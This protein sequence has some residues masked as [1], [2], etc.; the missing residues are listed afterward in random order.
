[1]TADITDHVDEG[2]VAVGVA[3]LAV[4][5]FKAVFETGWE[6]PVTMGCRD[7]SSVCWTTV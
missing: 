6:W 5:A 2:E 1:M 4:D 7:S 3:P